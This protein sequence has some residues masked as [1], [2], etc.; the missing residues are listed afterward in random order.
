MAWFITIVLLVIAAILIILFMSHYYRKATREIS[1]VRTG[2]GGQKVVLDGGCLALPFLHKVAEVNMRTS[3]LEIERAGPKSI[4]TK[5]RL[6]VDMGAE[7]YVRVQADADGVATA[8]QALAG[9]SFRAADLEE[10]LEG[11]LVDAMLSVAARYTMDELQDNR[12]AYVAEVT[13]MLGENLAQN[14]LML[15]SMSLTKIDQTPFHALDENNAFNA[16]GMRR[17]AE[18]IAVNKKERAVIEADS[19]VSVRQS[20]LDATKQKLTITREEEEAMITQ[21]R[22]IEIARSRSAAETAE[23]Q[24][25]SEKRRE[26]A[27]IEREQEVRASEIAR[28]MELRRQ[29]LESELNSAVKKSDNAVALAKKK[30]EEAKAEAAAIAAKAGEAEAEEKVRTV[31]ETAMAERDKS[32][33]LIRAA[34]QAEVDNTRVKSEAETITAMAEAKAKATL[35]HAKAEKDRLMSE[36]EGRAA[37]IAA[38][39]AQS[40]DLIAMKLDEARLRTLAQVVERMM[41]P[42]EK[43]EGIRINQISGFGGTGSS[44]GEGADKSTVNQVVDSV[45]GMALQLP[46]VQKLGEEVGMNIGD[47]VNGLTKSLESKSAGDTPETSSDDK[48]SDKKD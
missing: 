43:I 6:R 11:K 9:K 18:I 17:L 24:A 25:V 23:E 14:G 36:A 45:L 39:N 35:D 21:Q 44:G 12:A 1:V 42:A 22:E 20:Q 41:K 48:P 15:E 8:A 33:A 37:V 34:E 32:L 40:P 10:I 46:A 47:G 28:D 31:R 19:E 26:A 2:Q 30:G 16:L 27:R 7:F 13:D 38:E 29:T 5:D 3:K 4:I